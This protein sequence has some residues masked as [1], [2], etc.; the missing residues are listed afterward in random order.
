MGPD[1]PVTDRMSGTPGGCTQC[2]NQAPPLARPHPHPPQS[3]EHR[4]LLPFMLLVGLAQPQDVVRF[5]LAD[6]KEA[7][8]QAPL[9][10]ARG[11]PHLP[12]VSRL[13]Q[14]QGR[15]G[16]LAGWRGLQLP[17]SLLRAAGAGVL[18]QS[19]WHPGVPGPHRDGLCRMHTVPLSSRPCH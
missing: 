7:G 10:P 4:P 5:T 13:R 2:L 1:A 18:N 8:K 15:A 16:P 3:P 9:Q 17:A 12:L 14:R 11:S 6:L 19:N